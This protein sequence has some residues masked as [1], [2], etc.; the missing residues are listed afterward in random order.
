MCLS[1]SHNIFI[2][3]DENVC[4]SKE[5]QSCTDMTLETTEVAAEAETKTTTVAETETETTTV[6]ETETETGEKSESG[7][8]SIQPQLKNAGTEETEIIDKEKIATMTEAMSRVVKQL[9][10]VESVGKQ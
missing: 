7:D 4:E 1:L 3:A 2:L 9:V 6:V 10:P 8:L 5:K